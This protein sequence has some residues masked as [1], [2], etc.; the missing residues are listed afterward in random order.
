[1]KRS[2][3]IRSESYQVTV[4]LAMVLLVYLTGS[5][6][7]SGQSAEIVDRMQEST[8]LIVTKT[9]EQYGTGSGFLVGTSRHVVTNWHVVQGA[10]V[11]V[12]LSGQD[13]SKAVIKHQSQVKDLA[14]LELEQAFNR[15]A[16]AFA[17]RSMLRKAQVVY[18]MGFPSAGMGDNIETASAIREVKISRGIISAFVKSSGGIAL[19][20]TDAAINPGNSGGP[21]FNM[22]GQVVGINDMKSLTEVRT[23]AG[24]VVRVPEGEGVGWAIEVD[25][26]FPEL[27]R[28]QISYTKATAPC[29]EQAGGPVESQR[30]PLVLV[31]IIAAIVLGLVAVLLALTKQGRQMVKSRFTRSIPIPAA[32]PSPEVEKKP[33]LR[34]VSGQYAGMEIELNQ[35]PLVIGRDPRM[36]QLVITQ[37]A[38][39]EEVSGRHC[40]ITYDQGRQ[41][42]FIEDHWSSNGTFMESGKKIEPGKPVLLNNGQR[43]YLS[44]KGNMF[45]VVLEG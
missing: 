21:L 19:I 33:V 36:A 22:C 7:L 43:F 20:Q 13:K 11:I 40:T 12:V 15:P 37:G 29:V 10:G 16:V 41:Q 5:I 3:C 14:I 9:G 27:D 26:L 30:D 25:E 32:P 2:V 35:E 24:E 1:M 8:V 28:V 23:T 4:K 6:L 44:S 45:E 39:W 31:G 17:P 38:D 18:A 42:F 34:G